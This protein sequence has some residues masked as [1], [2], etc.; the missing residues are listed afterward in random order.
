MP[1]QD[2]LLTEL[3]RKEELGR[4]AK[5]APMTGPYLKSLSTT[6]MNV[7]C[8]QQD[9]DTPVLRKHLIAPLRDRFKS[10]NSFSTMSQ[11][12]ME[13]IDVLSDVDESGLKAR[14]WCLNHKGFQK[15]LSQESL[16]VL[17]W[18]LRD[19]RIWVCV[20]INIMSGGVGF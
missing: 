14:T 18:E 17:Y 5:A 20:D 19:H 13:M 1:T 2:D 15:G 4:T 16:A 7:L 6:L 8:N 10:D 3:V 11:L 12:N 9:I